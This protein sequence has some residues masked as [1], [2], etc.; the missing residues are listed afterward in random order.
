MRP[1][2]IAGRIALVTG[3][4]HGI[5]A[6][7]VRA[8]CEE[9][10]RVAALDVDAD[11]LAGL[12]ARLEAEGHSVRA[13]PA[14]VRSGSDVERVVASVEGSWGPIDLGANVAGVLGMGTVVETDDEEWRRMFAVN[15]DGVFHVSRALA[16][17]MQPRGRGSIVTVSSNAAGIPR[18]GMSAYAASKAACTMFTRCLGLELAGSGVR[19]NVVAP[20][21]TRT[22]MQE[23][24]WTD[25]LGEESV[26][27]GS[28]ETYRTGIPLRRIAEPRNVADAVIF[29]LS[30]LAAHITMAELYV[31]GGATLR[32]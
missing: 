19:C 10:A 20:G 21:S 2:G 1:T 25:E 31:D 11:A 18:H 5:G 17:R 26:I 15:T 27:R 14:D 9:G 32:A 3:A 7:V 16:R 4:A 6:E 23:S 24:M 29:L 12:V 28:L 8:L 30:D 22:R 13:E